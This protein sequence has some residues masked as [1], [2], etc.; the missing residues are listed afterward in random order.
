MRL[1]A[2]VGARSKELSKARKHLSSPRNSTKNNSRF[3][4]C[5]TND[6]GRGG[7]RFGLNIS[8]S[9]NSKPGKYTNAQVGTATTRNWLESQWYTIGDGDARYV[10][11]PVASAI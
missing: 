3:D 6:G 2:L 1:R 8:C 11:G 5:F 7:A 4:N 10:Q 9:L